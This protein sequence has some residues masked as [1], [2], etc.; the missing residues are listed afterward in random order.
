M[1]DKIPQFLQKSKLVAN[2]IFQ[3]L[4]EKNQEVHLDP[5]PTSFLL[6]DI[7]MYQK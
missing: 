3:W 2:S 1:L 4:Q 7:N 6:R 5:F